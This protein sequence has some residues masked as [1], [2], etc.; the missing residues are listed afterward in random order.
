VTLNWDCLGCSTGLGAGKSEDPDPVLLAPGKANTDFVPAVV[1]LDWFVGNENVGTGVA[2]ELEV[3]VVDGDETGGSEKKLGTGVLVAVAE[4]SSFVAGAGGVGVAGLV[5]KLGTTGGAGTGTVVEGVGAA[6]GFF[7]GS[8]VSVVV[9]APIA[10]FKCV[11][12]AETGV[13]KLGVV[14]VV[15]G[16]G[17][18]DGFF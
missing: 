9:V 11:E 16:A 2:V 15:A 1:G 18:G 10:G 5:N 7:A 4:G 13:D 12:N 17:E 6:N 3:V 14:V 8:F